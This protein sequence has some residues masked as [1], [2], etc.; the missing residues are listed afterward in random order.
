M[1]MRE[2]PCPYRIVDDFG[3]GFS[4]GCVAGVIFY[5]IRGVWYA[6]KR[7]KIMGGITLLK[8]RAPILGGKSL[9]MQVASHCGPDSSP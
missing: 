8:K 9:S 6:P 3:N 4:M 7:E 2:Q 5:F 1:A